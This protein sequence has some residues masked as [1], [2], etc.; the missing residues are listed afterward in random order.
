VYRFRSEL[1][2]DRARVV[3]GATGAVFELGHGINPGVL[4]K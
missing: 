1:G 2:L 4:A 3:V